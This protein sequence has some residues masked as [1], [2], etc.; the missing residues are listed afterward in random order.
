MK[1]VTDEDLQQIKT[2]RE[3]LVDIVTTTGELQLSRYMAENQLNA[4]D[5]DITK[6]RVRFKEFQEQERV[7]FEQLQQRYG[8][9]NINF[10]TGEIV[11]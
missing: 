5:D 1:T 3:T 8:T 10:E 2:L 11:E 7:L 6:Q 4:I 9:G